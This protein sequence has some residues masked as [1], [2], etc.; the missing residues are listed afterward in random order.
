MKLAI[1]TLGK[2]L[3]SKVCELNGR[4]RPAVGL[5]RQTASKIVWLKPRLL[6]NL[7]QNRRAEFC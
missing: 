5:L 7:G 3:L 6:G 1:P 2:V 4:G